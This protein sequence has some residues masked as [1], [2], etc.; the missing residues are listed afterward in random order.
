MA[1]SN[2]LGFTG[3]TDTTGGGEPPM[4]TLE[5]RVTRI[6]E[7]MATKDQLELAK[8]Q[9]ELEILKSTTEIKSDLASLRLDSKNDIAG[10]KLDSKNDIANLRL[11]LHSM[12]FKQITWIV[13][14][15][16]ASASLLFA[17]LR[18]FK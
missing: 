16:L 17:A 6:E 11:E 8:S 13:G 15:G 4:S 5:L 14:T 10:L 18:F 3:D 2:V 9:L 12:M 1:K 7:T